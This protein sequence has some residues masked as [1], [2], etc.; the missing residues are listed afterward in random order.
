MLRRRCVGLSN[1]RL[2]L[3]GGVKKK[4]WEADKVREVSDLEHSTLDPTTEAMEP[5]GELAGGTP[6]IDCEDHQMISKG[7]LQKLLSTTTVHHMGV[8]LLPDAP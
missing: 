2:L 1:S 8:S 7:P 6:T 4:K 3:Q 5:R